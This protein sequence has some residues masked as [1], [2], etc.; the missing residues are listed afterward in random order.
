MT[1]G[2]DPPMGGII[3][4]YPE[5]DLFTRVLK[6]GDY[7]LAPQRKN[8]RKDTALLLLKIEEGP[9]SQGIEATPRSWKQQGKEFSPESLHKGTT[10]ALHSGFDQASPASDF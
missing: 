4:G 9:M 8:S 1:K 10:A 6:I 7:F 2:E 5:P 3:L